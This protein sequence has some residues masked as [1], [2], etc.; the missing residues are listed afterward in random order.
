MQGRIPATQLLQEVSFCVT[1]GIL[2]EDNMGTIYLVRKQQAGEHTKHIDMHWHFI[3]QL[4]N[5]KELTV[6][7][8]H[9]KADISMKTFL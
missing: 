4:Y 7:S 5:C 9:N 3:H 6:R 1:P 8:E 2:L